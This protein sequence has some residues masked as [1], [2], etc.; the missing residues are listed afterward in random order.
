M[1]L[2]LIVHGGAGDIASDD[3]T[4]HREGARKATQVGWEIL[5]RGGSALNAV[6]AAIVVME[7]HPSLLRSESKTL[8]HGRRSRVRRGLRLVLEPRWRSRD[9]CEFHGR[10]NA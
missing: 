8:H 7:R 2:A 3:V 4:P 5:L 9:G 1:K 10:S 6:E